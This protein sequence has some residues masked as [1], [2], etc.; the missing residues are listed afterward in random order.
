MRIEV[1]PDRAAQTI[2]AAARL[3]QAANDAI[4]ARGDAC[5]ALSGGATPAPTYA[6]LAALP[7][8][9]SKVRFLLV[10]ER[11]VPLSHEASNEALLR[12][13]LAP[14][15]SAGAR[16]LP[17]S[18]ADL[19]LAEAAD[20]ADAA[21]APFTI[22]AALMGMGADGH[23]ASWFAGAEGLSA[24]LDRATPRTVVA[25]RAVQAPGSAERLTL[26]SATLARIPR[27]LL[28]IQGDAKRAA[29]KHAITKT[30]R[31]AP[32]TALF[33]TQRSPEVLWAA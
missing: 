13:A 10:D 17:M 29:L 2:E 12:H 6:R 16:L 30:Q 3:A 23:T 14:A 9:W 26:T 33:T 18:A 8:D 21:Y 7:I 31:E 20:R 1:F 27:I 5:L 32:V 4:A 24:A 28:L 25:V 22:D 15:L 11:F 19:T